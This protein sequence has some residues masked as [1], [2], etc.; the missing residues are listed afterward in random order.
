MDLSE[1]Q[2]CELAKKIVSI[3]NVG[4]KKNTHGINKAKK[5]FG[6][7]ISDFA[8]KFSEKHVTLKVV[9]KSFPQMT[10]GIWEELKSPLFGPF[11]WSNEGKTK[12]LDRVGETVLIQYHNEN[13]FIARRIMDECRKK[14]AHPMWMLRDSLLLKE[15]YATSTKQA[16]EELP[17]F[18]INLWKNVDKLIQFQFVDDPFWKTG[19]DPK[20]LRLGTDIA[21]LYRKNTQKWDWLLVGWPYP[22][23]AE[24]FGVKPEWFSDMLFEALE[25]SFSKETHVAQ[26]Y[27]MD[28]LKGKS[29]VRIE[30]EDGT[31]LV[32]SVKGRKPMWDHTGSEKVNNLPSGEV[33]VA[34][35]ENSAEGKIFFEKIN[36]LGHG[37]VEGLWLEFRNGKLDLFKAKKNGEFLKAW[38]AENTPST[39]IPGE[40]GIGCNKSAR[41]S[42]FIL[43]DEKIFGTIHIALGFNVE[44]GGKNNASGHMDMVKDMSNGKMFFDEKLVMEKG[45]PVKR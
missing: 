6:S 41:Y 24:V 18:Q 11:L 10:K 22:K 40:L 4:K 12:V 7:W 25:A 26:E 27:Y 28:E 3:M 16:L 8:E 43:T 19:I 32:L 14:G 2:Q 15:S 37:F 38:L 29:T 23:T 20:K 1:K 36:V 42:G 5:K 9:R 44:F 31:D 39:R 21:E 17:Q 34:P 35:V 13:E 45:L 30:H 33:F